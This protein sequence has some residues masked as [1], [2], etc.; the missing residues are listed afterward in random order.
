MYCESLWNKAKGEKV[1][2]DTRLAEIDS[3]FEEGQIL[4]TARREVCLDSLEQALQESYQL[5]EEREET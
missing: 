1:G 5:V 4:S 3:R 2:E